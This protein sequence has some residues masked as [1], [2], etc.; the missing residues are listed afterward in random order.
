MPSIAVTEWRRVA[1]LGRQIDGSGARHIR[2]PE[3]RIR[4]HSVLP[5]PVLPLQGNCSPADQTDLARHPGSNARC[6]E[7]DL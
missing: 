7:Q 2:R 5:L 1:C 4:L 6:A 3:R